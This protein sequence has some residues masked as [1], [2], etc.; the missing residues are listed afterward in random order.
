MLIDQRTVEFLIRNNLT[1][2]DF[3]FLMNLHSGASWDE[4]AFPTDKAKLLLF[5]Y[6]NESNQVTGKTVELLEKL[7]SEN[8]VSSWNSINFDE[9]WNKYPISDEHS[10][11]PMTRPLRVR[12]EECRIL[13]N[14]VIKNGISLHDL[15][16]A[17]DKEVTTRRNRSIDSNEMKY[18]TNSLN[19]LQGQYY[20]PWMEEE[21]KTNSQ[22]QIKDDRFNVL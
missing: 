11:F 4:S 1:I 18:M 6:I 13:F 16:S 19:Y 9:W 8:K 21:N 5:E 2:H 12:K 14:K 20:L 10:F 3:V 17:L 15:L 7:L 22:G